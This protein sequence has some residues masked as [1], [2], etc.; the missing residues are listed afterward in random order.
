LVCGVLAPTG[1]PDDDAAFVDIKTAWVLEGLAHGHA[2]AVKV[3]PKELLLDQTPSRVV[4]SEELVDYNAF[5]EANYASF[6][7][8]ADPGT[9]PITGLLVFPVSTKDTSLLKAKVNASK[10]LQMVVPL[11][12]VS[13]MLGYV[14]RLRLL[15]DGLALLMV[16]FTIILLGLVT[17]LSIRVRTR[18]LQTLSRIGVSRTRIVAIFASEIAAIVGIGLLLALFATSLLAAAPPD[19]VKLL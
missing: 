14:A 19:L 8:H 11:D 18:E 1:T 9:L 17:M 4:V 12:A 15:L 3:I 6:H 7:L 13:E 2:D 16:A 10:T 5:N